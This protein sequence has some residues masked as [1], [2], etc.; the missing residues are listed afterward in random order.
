MFGVSRDASGRA[1]G[2]DNR[3]AGAQI[4]GIFATKSAEI[5]RCKRGLPGEDWHLIKIQSDISSSNEV[6]K[7]YISRIISITYKI[8]VVDDMPT[9]CC[10]D[11][12]PRQ[13]RPE[14]PRALTT[15]LIAYGYGGFRHSKRVRPRKTGGGAGSM[16]HRRLSIVR[17]SALL[18]Q[19]NNEPTHAAVSFA[20]GRGS[21]RGWRVPDVPLV[22]RVHNK[23]ARPP[24]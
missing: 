19:Q 15:Q 21:E 18:H 24:R 16:T 20:A 12:G 6:F 8:G 23:L 9:V 4:P 10:A 5:E 22:A 2:T 13:K 11:G 7:S 3:P 1:R 14:S 17:G